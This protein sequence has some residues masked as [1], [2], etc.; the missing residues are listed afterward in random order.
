MTNNV[1]TLIAAAAAHSP[2][3][4][5]QAAWFAESLAREGWSNETLQYAGN[6]DLVA[7]LG[8]QT[9]DVWLKG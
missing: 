4:A 1:E 6:P 3:A 2:E 5:K 8:H 7:A 9:A